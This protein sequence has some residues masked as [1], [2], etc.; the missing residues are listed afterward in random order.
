MARPS[1]YPWDEIRLRYMAMEPPQEIAKDYSGLSA[2]Q[3]SN[4][5]SKERWADAREE[6][7]TKIVYKAE[8]GQEAAMMDAATM[9]LEIEQQ[10]LIN[11][12][13]LAREGKSFYDTVQDLILEKVE[14]EIPQKRQTVMNSLIHK[15][16]TVAGAALP[17]QLTNTV[18]KHARMTADMKK[19]EEQGNKPIAINFIA[20]EIKQIT[21]ENTG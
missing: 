18:Y 3:V 2:K 15:F 14:E 1:K 10:I 11:T 8:A 4:K 7:R 19:N 16:E 5:A 6:R 9:A 17:P 21:Q 13:M 12:L 20:K